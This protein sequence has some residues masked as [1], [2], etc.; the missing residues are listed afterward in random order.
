MARKI[1]HTIKLV[2]HTTKLVVR[3]V[4]LEVHTVTLVVHTIFSSV[5]TV[6]K[7]V[8]TV[9]SRKWTYAEF[10]ECINLQYDISNILI[11][12]ILMNITKTNNLS[13]KFASAGCLKTE[14]DYP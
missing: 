7:I 12:Y 13:A 14:Y 3:T 5:H 8:H 9:F 2:V 10:R 11:L 4:R 6:R 1:V